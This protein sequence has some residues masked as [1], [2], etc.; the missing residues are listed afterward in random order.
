MAGDSS[1]TAVLAATAEPRPAWATSVASTSHRQSRLTNPDA[2][3][4]VSIA[5]TSTSPRRGSASPISSGQPSTVTT[6]P[7]G[8]AWANSAA[9]VSACIA[10][11]A[12]QIS[13]DASPAVR[14]RAQNQTSGPDVGWRQTIRRQAVTS[15]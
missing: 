1:N 3:P 7:S 4:A 10:P 6:A 2:S 13:V 15:A 14:T 9:V 5:S 8:R 12:S 11:A